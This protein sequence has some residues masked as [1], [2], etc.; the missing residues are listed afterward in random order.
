MGG[1][2]LSLQLHTVL[3]QATTGAVWQKGEKRDTVFRPVMMR[4]SDAS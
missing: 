2:N 4:R 1:T 3:Q